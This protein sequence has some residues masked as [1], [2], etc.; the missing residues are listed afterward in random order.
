MRLPA[1]RSRPVQCCRRTA[2]GAHLPAH[3]PPPHLSTSPTRRYLAL[4]L[5]PLSD[6]NSLA[7][8]SP[9]LVAAAA[10]YLLGDPT[11]AA[12]YCA[13]PV[14]LVRPQA[15]GRPRFGPP[16]LLPA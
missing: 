3:R 9:V 11:P 8:I 2:G 14:C 13:M 15:A 16:V 1:P 6:A 12:V 4:S 5:I 7:F 10:P